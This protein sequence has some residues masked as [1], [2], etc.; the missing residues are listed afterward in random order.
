MYLAQTVTGSYRAVKVVNRANFEMERTFEREFE[1]IV[2][3]ENV[4]Q[5][6]PGLVDVLHVGRAADSSYYY[7]VMALA[8]DVSGARLDAETIDTYQPKTLASELRLIRVRDIGDCLA[9]G[10]QM[11]GA[12]D[13]LHAAGL[14]HRDVKPANIIY[15]SGEPQLADI[16]LVARSGQRTYVGTEGYVPPEG[17]GTSSADL[18][19][20]GMVLYE[21]H[22][23]KD[24]MEF[25]ELPTNHQLGPTVNRD[26]WRAL[27]QVI[28]RAGSPTP[29]RRFESGGAMANALGAIRELPDGAAPAAAPSKSKWWIWLMP[30]LAIAAIAAAIYMSRSGDEEPVATTETEPDSIAAEA[31]PSEDLTHP[32]TTPADPEPPEVED[33]IV[34]EP[35]PPTL[36]A[37]PVIDPEPEP[38]VNTR[39]V[40]LF[41]TPTGAIVW[42]GDTQIGR[43]TTR[44]RAFDIGEHSFVF[45]LDGYLEKTET[46]TLKPGEQPHQIFASLEKDNRPSAT[47]STWKNSAGLLFQRAKNLPNSPLVAE[48]DKAIFDHFLQATGTDQSTLPMATATAISA[49]SSSSAV[50]VTDPALMWAFCDWMTGLDREG[51]YLDERTYLKPAFE[52]QGN[53]FHCQID[54]RFAAVDVVSEPIGAEIY[55]GDRLVGVTPTEVPLR[56]GPYQ[57]QLS[58]DGHKPVDL[59]GILQPD[60][61]ERHS[62]TLRTDLSPIYGR[63]WKN[64]LGMPLTPVGD[65][66]F[67]THETRYVDYDFYLQL[68]PDA[69]PPEVVGQSPDHPVVGIS[70]SD[71][72][73][74]CRWLTETERER[75]TIRRWHTYRLPTDAEWSQAAQESLYP[76]GIEWPPPDGTGN[77]ADLST[78]DLDFSIEDYRDG[79]QTTAPVGS[80]SPTASGLYDLSGNVWEWVSDTRG[81]RGVLRGGG[82]DTYDR[83]LLESAYRNEADPKARSNRMFGFRYVL[84]DERKL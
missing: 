34:A 3:Y 72:E 52:F 8:D 43:T 42:L 39:E 58:L 36:V 17:P 10:R 23:G 56:L 19:A 24:R 64:G 48:V 26:E 62:A 50:M 44:A 57:L 66:W 30:V 31:T 40:Q 18:Y 2:H 55:D 77:F 71:A 67:A 47:N 70:R 4:S 9:L 45:R 54:N 69:I 7:Y 82:Y 49:T 75:G 29:D 1:G 59:Q 79:Y 74:F 35:A 68:S 32:P 46:V 65:I 33:P 6:H 63:S 27:N 53:R 80:F 78:G 81:E 41:S 51:K 13:H 15:A 5:G 76:W 25:P 83:E 61:I 37:E 12:L 16:G 22:T 14:T 84:V 60:S 73:L 20:L 28:C 21:M 38:A 11:A